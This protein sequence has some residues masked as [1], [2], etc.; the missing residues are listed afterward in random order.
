[1]NLIYHLYIY[2]YIQPR[3]SFENQNQQQ[4]AVNERLNRKQQQLSSRKISREEK[5][6]IDS[7]TI[8]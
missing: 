7:K 1:M 3:S 8:N 6:K 2:I 4:A 5:K